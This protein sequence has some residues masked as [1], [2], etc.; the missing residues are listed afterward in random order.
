M[1]DIDGACLCGAIRYEAT[2]DPGQVRIC[3]CT[4][5][6]V[7][8]A[9]SF[10]VGVLV[11]K[12]DFRLL[13]GTPRVYVKTAESGRPRALAF[14]ADCGTSLYGT[15]PT[16]PRQYSLRLGTARQRARL[17]P[18]VQIWAGEAMPWLS[19]IP[20][21]PQVERQSGRPGRGPSEESNPMHADTGIASEHAAGGPLPT[22]DDARAW[23]GPAMAARSDWILS[24]DADDVAELD[25]AVECAI[26]ADVDLVTMTEVGFRLPRLAPRLAAIR[27]ELLD[28]RG[29][30]LIRG[31]PSERRTLRQSATA[32]RGIG[33]H[34]GEAV[35]QN[36]KGH[37]LGHVANLGLDY[38]DP[39]TRGYQTTAELRYHV[40]GGD[41]VGLLCVRPSRSG[42]LSRIVSSTTVWNEIVR[43]RPDLARVLMEPY[44]FSR[45][46]EVGAGQKRWFELPLFQPH[47][48]RMIA[49]V[50][51]SAIDKAQAFDDAP[52][53]TAEQAEALRLVQAVADDPQVRL[54]MDF[55]PGD[56]QFLCNHVTLHSRTAYED[57]P[58]PERRRHLLRLWLA[59]DGG[60]DLPDNLT[61]KFQRRT[62]GGRPDGI[63]VPGVARVAP[64][65]PG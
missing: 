45:W 12:E 29:F 30:V 11:P 21:I 63:N 8:S 62:A 61:T 13:S 55:R 40:D 6:Q 60:P 19:Q 23:R 58:E 50:V 42:G 51:Q 57:W 3:H 59:C 2:I 38:S 22:F 37:V 16:D 32:F 43:R 31:W 7:Q 28:G 36:G 5:C 1:M 46:G 9:T 18:T 24:L 52:R 34:F 49:V 56:M 48:G 26:A 41:V 65:E 27:R 64:L 17:V 44:A 54:D 39:H 10:R 25:A 53:L 35:S 33:A 20:Q 4:Q 15:S 47:A 14:C